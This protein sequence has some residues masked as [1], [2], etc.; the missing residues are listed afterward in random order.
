MNE[1]RD[2]LKLSELLPTNGTT[3]NA[4][5]GN[6]AYDCPN[7]DVNV[8]KLLT[9]SLEKTGFSLHAVNTIGASRFWTYVNEEGFVHV[10]FHP[11]V[12]TLRVTYG[13]NAYLPSATPTEYERKVT[14]TITQMHMQMADNNIACQSITRRITANNGAPGMSYL[15]RLADGRF[16]ILDGGNNDGIVTPAYQ[17]ERGEWLAG[18]PT[19]TEDEK[20][21]YDTMLSMLPEG[22]TTPT[23]ALWVITHPHGDHMLLAT[24]FL[25][26][27][28]NDFNLE[29]VAFNFLENDEFDGIMK[30]WATDFRTR[31]KQNFPK[32][33][34]WILHTG[35]K[36]YLPDCTIEVL[37]TAEDYVCSGSRLGDG[38]NISAALL[39]TMGKTTFIALGDA[40]PVT[41]T[42][43]RDAYRTA[44]QA[45]ILQ[46]AHHGF[47]GSGDARGMYQI[48]DPKICFWACDEYRFQKDRRNIGSP[49]QD[50]RFYSHY[51]L[52]NMP[53]TRGDE[54]GE[55]EHYSSSYTTTIN[56]ET[57]KKIN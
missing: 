55:R 5:D 42:F 32:V 6:F 30:I 9:A 45:D 1:I 18:E 31:A 40:Y 44:L 20:R 33:Q 10:M 51:W 57:G 26:T 36:L 52:R 48:I 3:Y 7:T 15:L 54:V 23:V 53:W 19:K 47:D 38:N 22:E 49:Q 35:Q 56:A 29:M 39:I 11:A 41:C 2:R 4:G 21:L 43:M 8:V 27:Y 46:L 50:H 25:E 14:P 34:E 17:N 13:P 16:V 12:R 24:C 37:C 28:K